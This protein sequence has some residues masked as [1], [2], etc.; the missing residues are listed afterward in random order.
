[1]LQ[2]SDEITPN[3]DLKHSSVQKFTEAFTYYYS[4]GLTKV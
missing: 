3:M 2:N 1:V 4:H